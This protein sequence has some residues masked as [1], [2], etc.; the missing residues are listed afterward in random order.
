[1]T[2]DLVSKDSIKLADYLFIRLQQL[3]VQS[4]FGV[5]GDYNLRLLDFIEPG[6]LHWVG[7]CNELNAAYAAD[8]YAR[9]NGLGAL[10]TTFGVGELSAINAIAG[11]YA[12]RA[13]IVH[14]V[15]TPPRATQDSR[16]LVHHTFADGEYGRFALMQEHVTAAQSNLTDPRTA[17]DQIDWILEQAL[18]YCRPVYLQVPLD[19]VDVVVS[20][21]NLRSKKISIPS[22]PRP[23]YEPQV[24]KQ[25]TE[26]IYSAKRPLIFVDGESR[27][28]NI[29]DQIDTLIRT[30]NWPTWTTTFAKGL[31][32]EELSNV[33]GIYTAS[34]GSE[35]SKAYFDSADLVLNFGPHNSN[36]N[37]QM[38]TT[39]P[40][41]AASITFSGTTIRIGK[42]LYRDISPRDVLSQLLSNLN[43]SHIP[44][45]EGP[46]K[47]SISLSHINKSDLI[48]QKDF[49]HY[50]N[51]IFR[52]GD[53]ILTE[54]GT[55]SHGGR[56]FKLPSNTYQFAAVTWLSIGYM[57]PAT[58]GAALAQREA[59]T[60][61][62]TNGASTPKNRVILFIGDGSLQMTVQEI[63]TII[64]EKLDV[65]IFLINNDGYTIE[66]VIH[67]RN[68]VYNDIATWKHQHMLSF[69]GADDEHAAKNNFT[70][71]TWGELETVLQTEQI[72]NGSGLRV[73]EVFMGREDCQGQL[74]TLL[75]NQIAKEGRMDS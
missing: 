8:A 70:A 4:I 18:I 66:R 69:F 15:G 1:M 51:P 46:A 19:M 64:K 7:N 60:S 59:K 67:G 43:T 39:I 27:P 30:T 29:L 38:F 50:V 31:I 13:A 47:P 26:R 17:P 45:A 36:T 56:E 58:L 40:N 35:E 28:L 37:T 57:L 62:A 33:Y 63:S 6:G 12:E 2:Q 55:A 73:V 20:T 21:S 42:D 75:N 48:T 23:E 5:P 68:Q 34:Y 24:L 14:I 9:I 3:G 25:I 54:T 11:A 71:K 32:N 72:Q 52:S 49:Y 53:I 61:K 10:V 22:A 41:A 16:L 44:K 74:L 65:I